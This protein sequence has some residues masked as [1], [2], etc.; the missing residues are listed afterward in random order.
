MGLCWLQDQ[1]SDHIQ[2]GSKMVQWVL[3]F[4]EASTLM[5]SQTCICASFGIAQ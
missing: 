4:G 2:M 5:S 1:Q 3:L